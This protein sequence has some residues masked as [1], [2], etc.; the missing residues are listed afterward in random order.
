MWLGGG[1][2]GAAAGGTGTAVGL[3]GAGGGTLVVA[4]AVAP[5]LTAELGVVGGAVVGVGGQIYAMLTGGTGGGDEAAAPKGI[6]PDDAVPEG[7]SF[8][9]DNP[10]YRQLKDGDQVLQYS[11][12]GEELAVDWVDGGGAASMLKRILAAEGSG[13]RR[14]SG[15]ATDKLASLS[16]KALLRYGNQVASSLGEGWKASIEFVANKRYLVF[17]R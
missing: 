15:Y 1:L 4:P 16:D 7:F 17:T 14:I 5:V 12:K 13:V 11:I 8:D 3:S 2:G 10:I 6:R 9:I